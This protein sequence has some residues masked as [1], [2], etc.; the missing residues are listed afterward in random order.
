MVQQHRLIKSHIVRR[1]AIAGIYETP[2]LQHDYPS[3]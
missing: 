2:L 1:V 3:S